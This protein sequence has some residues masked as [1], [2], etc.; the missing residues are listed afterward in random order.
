MSAKNVYV[1]QLLK[2][3]SLGLKLQPAP[4]TRTGQQTLPASST[5]DSSSQRQVGAQIPGVRECTT[6][7]DLQEG[8][9]GGSAQLACQQTM[10]P[11]LSRGTH[12]PG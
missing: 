2:Y 5:A 7:D 8:N 11:A 12:T 1:E 4:Y 9:R 3:H 6:R 10:G